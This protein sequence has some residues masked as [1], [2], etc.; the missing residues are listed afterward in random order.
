V[1]DY[2]DSTRATYAVVAALE[3]RGNLVFAANAETLRYQ[4]TDGVTTGER[5][6][7]G[8]VLFE[9]DG[10]PSANEA[11][12]EGW[13]VAC[14]EVVDN[15][16][17]KVGRFG[18]H[19]LLQ[20]EG[21]VTKQTGRG[22]RVERT[23]GR[24]NHVDRKDRGF[25]VR[26]RG[27]W[28]AVWVQLRQFSVA[29]VLGAMGAEFRRRRALLT[30]PI[31]SAATTEDS[32]RRGFGGDSAS[33]ERACDRVTA[34]FHSSLR[35]V[36]HRRSLDLTTPACLAFFARRCPPRG[37]AHK[38]HFG[39]MKTSDHAASDP[40][41]TASSQRRPHIGAK[42]KMGQKTGCCLPCTLAPLKRSGGRGWVE[43]VDL[44]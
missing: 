14:S 7:R 31:R 16:P 43:W 17:H 5:A 24:P 34:S 38:M 15:P 19:A 30:S 21:L 25:V 28:L 11:F 37:G 3:R 6:H 32:V 23:K 13:G 29:S 35:S 12:Q 40:E 2:L 4:A 27:G 8:L 36:C 41:D 39:N 22:P 10:D 1:G 20:E 42:F 18:P 44:G 26:Q 33:Y 9:R